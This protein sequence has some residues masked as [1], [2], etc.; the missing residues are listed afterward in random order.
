MTQ[1]QL[2]SDAKV[3]EKFGTFVFAL[4]KPRSPPAFT[5]NLPSM[6][7]SRA[8]GQ[9]LLDYYVDHV[10]WIYQIIH[11]PSVQSILDTTYTKIEQNQVPEY[12]HVALIATIFTLSAYFS[13]PQSNLYIHHTE[14]KRLAYRWLSVA[15]E[16]LAA[17]NCLSVPTIEALQ[18]LILISQHLMPNIGAIATLRTLASTSMYTARAMG[19]HKID[20]PANKARRKNTE[21]DWVTIE[22]KRRIWWHLAASDWYELLLHISSR[23]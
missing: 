3:C 11:V 14:A 8:Q 4:T 1:E 13:S 15:Q 10:N 23:L 20:S 16:A 9:T 2:S 19:L 7:P 6:L 18:S 22:V 5:L 12:S 21:V 17:S